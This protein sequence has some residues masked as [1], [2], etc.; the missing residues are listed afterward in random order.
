MERE[1]TTPTSKMQSI[2][3][4]RYPGGN[5]LSELSLPR[6]REEE[7]LPISKVQSGEG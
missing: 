6:Y 1:D 7:T 3:T 2:G 4:R 5:A